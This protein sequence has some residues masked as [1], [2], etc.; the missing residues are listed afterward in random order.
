ML[1]SKSCTCFTLGKKLMY[2]AMLGL[3]FVLLDYNIIFWLILYAGS[4]IKVILI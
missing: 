3:V 2:A 4:Y 1:I